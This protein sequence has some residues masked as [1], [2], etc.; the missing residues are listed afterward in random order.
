MIDKSDKEIIKGGVMLMALDII[1][2][3]GLL[4]ASVLRTIS[5]IEVEKDEKQKQAI[6]IFRNNLFGVSDKEK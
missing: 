3:G 2:N 6:R 5:L 1:C 4:T